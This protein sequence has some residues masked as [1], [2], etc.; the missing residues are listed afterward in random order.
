MGTSSIIGTS[1]TF[2]GIGC[3]IGIQSGPG[4]VETGEGH[5]WKHESK[6]RLLR[7]NML[8]EPWV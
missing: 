4:G 2:P 3:S 6:E 1:R 5:N 7:C 8:T